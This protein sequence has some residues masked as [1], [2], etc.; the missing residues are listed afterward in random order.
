[1]A[2]PVE[3]T[4]DESNNHGENLIDSPSEV[5]AHGSHDLTSA[6]AADL[7]DWLRNESGV[8]ATE[9]K[10]KHL[11]SFEKDLVE[12]L[13]GQRLAGRSN[14][15]LTETSFFVVGKVVDLLVEELTHEQDIDLYAS[16][17]ARA[18]ARKFYSEGSRAIGRDAWALLLSR[19]NSL[20]RVNQRSAPE[21]KATVDEFFTMVESA[22]RISTRRNVT[23][24]LELVLSARRH[25]QSFQD[26][27]GDQ[28]L[29][30]LEPMYP[31]VAQTAR[32]W[33]G[34]KRVEI[35]LRH[36]RA[37]SLEREGAV[38]ALLDVL[39][40]PGEFIRYVNPISIAGITLHD[41]KQDDRVQ[42]ADLIAGFGG[43]VAS[44]ALARTSDL[45]DLKLLRPMVREGLWGDERSWKLLT[46]APW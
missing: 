3:V 10:S 36:D 25:A 15:H 6:E 4:C 33:F 18:M 35:E 8:K 21:S 32:H 46:A 23:E 5:F 13:F 17:R 19:F 7:L 28:I 42:V 27:L 43:Q 34:V 41:S 45:D 44:A 40:R 16:G 9:F 29:P 20:M 14:V 39:R 11:G 37:S 2:N 31:A 12:E 22:L 30:A 1:M 26:S 38:D 24:V